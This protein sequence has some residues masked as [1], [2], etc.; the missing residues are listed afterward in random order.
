MNGWST[1]RSE[2]GGNIQYDTVM[3]HV[4]KHLSKP[5]KYNT[6]SEP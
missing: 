1:G 5:T 3:T 2:G 4:I 6:K